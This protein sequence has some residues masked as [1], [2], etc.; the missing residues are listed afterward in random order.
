MAQ[1]DIF[2]VAHL[3]RRAG[4]GATWDELEKYA[5]Q[6]YE[7]TVE[8]LLYPENAPP[9]LEDEDI[10]RRYHPD[11][12]DF[13]LIDGAQTYWVYRMINTRRPL[14]E[15]LALFWHGIFATG[16][17]KFDEPKAMT[18]QLEMFRRSGLG[19]FKNLLVQ[20][21]HDPAMIFWLDNKDNH[22]DAVNENYGR[23]ILELFSMGVG[24][25]TEDDVRQASRAF[26]GWTLRNIHHHAIVAAQNISEPYGRIDAHFEYRDDDHDQGEKTFLGKTGNFNGEDII[27]I[28]CQQ[29]ATARF[30]SRHLYNFFVADEPQVPAWGTVPPRDPKAI[31]A[32][33]NA[34]VNYGYDIRSMLRVLFN[35]DF[36]KNATF[37]R[38]KSPAEI[39]AGSARVA[40]T[41]RFPDPYDLTLASDIGSMGQEVLDPPSVE[42][43][44]TGREWINSSALIQRINFAVKQFSG[45]ESPGVQS[46]V[47]RIRAQGAYTSPE[48]LVD[49]CLEL[50]GPMTVLAETMDQLLSH[51]SSGGEIQ[52]GDELE[53]RSAA[54][55]ISELLQLI[56][57]T[58]EYQ[59]A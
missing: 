23:E 29:P 21:S 6:G 53:A 56:A 39:I 16:W 17:T 49:S 35:S 30:V 46:I 32:L 51:V 8:E 58:R 22:G 48:Q 27:D 25:Y 2:L 14:E 19:S 24:N 12:N 31:E 54:E 3:L 41:Y 26:T 11:Q 7:A 18:R 44:H 15:K 57:S 9:A 38:V 36:F 40:G 42:G 52:F 10:I 4:F 1:T 55:R 59:M 20:V 13:R 37:A 34:F 45:V 50:M 5:A 43:W 28:I 33:M 47:S